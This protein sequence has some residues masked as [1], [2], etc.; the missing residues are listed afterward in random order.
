MVERDGQ[1]AGVL[2]RE[3]VDRALASGQPALTARDLAR[4]DGWRWRI[5]MDE[6]LEALIGTEGMRHLGAV[7]AVDGE[8]VLRGVV[9]LD[10]VRRALAP[11]R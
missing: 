1:F 7:F 11:A 10:Q 3:A 6:P 5:D 4:E 9:T 8:G 2:H